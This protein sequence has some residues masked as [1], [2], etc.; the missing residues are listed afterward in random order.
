[1]RAESIL[2]LTILDSGF[3]R[4]DG[5]AGVCLRGNDDG[6]VQNLKWDS[7]EGTVGLGFGWIGH[8]NGAG[9]QGGQ[10]GEL[11]LEMKAL[12]TIAV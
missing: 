10:C 11:A 9:A 2:S 5:Y 8:R 6:V 1:M 7:H 3:R 4:K 12:R